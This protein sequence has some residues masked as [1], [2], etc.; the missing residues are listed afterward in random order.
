MKVLPLN[1]IEQ[2]DSIQHGVIPSINKNI[3]LLLKSN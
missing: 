3:F 2:N 1:I